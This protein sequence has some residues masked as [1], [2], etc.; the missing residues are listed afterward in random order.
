M[1]E[2]INSSTPP[3]AIP[4][5]RNGSNASQTRGYKIR[6]RSANGQHRTHRM[7]QSRNF[8]ITDLKLRL[9]VYE[10]RSPI[11]FISRSHGFRNSLFKYRSGPAIAHAVGHLCAECDD[12]PNLPVLYFEDFGYWHGVWCREICGT[13]GAIRHLHRRD[14]GCQNHDKSHGH[15]FA[16]KADMLSL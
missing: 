3:T 4:T 14:S 12:I 13:G 15:Q 2:P 5:I 6:A 1:I 10:T 7:H 9:R 8:T 16:H 11:F